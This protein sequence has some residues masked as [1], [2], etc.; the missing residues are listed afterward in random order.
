MPEVTTVTTYGDPVEQTRIVLGNRR[1]L[2]PV[3]A[4]LGNS[5]LRF[6]LLCDTD[7][8]SA[9]AFSKN[10]P[11][12]PCFPLKPCASF[13]GRC[14][15]QSAVVINY[16]RSTF[17][18]WFQTCSGVCKLKPQTTGI[19]IPRNLQCRCFIWKLMTKTVLAMDNNFKVNTSGK[20]CKIAILLDFK[21]HTRCYTLY[22][23]WLKRTVICKT[24][25]KS[26][27]GSD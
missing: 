13:A 24:L 10:K 12:A 8:I 15:L 23:K 1:Y 20:T 3:R 27:K 7:I 2:L 21:N 9:D 14:Q 11:E 26:C 5:Q 25:G 16:P 4:F 19:L 17:I 6:T 18:C 22:A